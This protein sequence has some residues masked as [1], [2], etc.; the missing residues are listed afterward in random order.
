MTITI[1][2]LRQAGASDSL[3][4]RVA[5]LEHAERIATRRAQN[6]INKQNQRSRQ[7]FSAD[8][9]DSAD[10]GSPL[11]SSPS[12]FSPTPPH[13]TTPPS[14]P[15][16]KNVPSRKATEPVDEDFEQFW[17]G[18]PRREG[19]NPKHL[20]RRAFLA[21]R[22]AVDPSVIV[23]G[24]AAYAAS[25]EGVPDRKFIPMAATWLNQRRWEDLAPPADVPRPETP[26]E[27]ANR[28]YW[29]QRLA[30]KE[31][32]QIQRPVVRGS[33]VDREGGGEVSCHRGP[34]SGVQRVDGLVPLA[35]ISGPLVHAEC[36][37][38]QA[39][40]DLAESVATQSIQM[41]KYQ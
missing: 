8:S 2:M 6:R 17:K 21:A 16:P 23:R 9:A 7:Q 40:C 39:R 24:A 26:E 33:D 37:A 5:E 22:R 38:E 32:D 13:I 15:S 14:F 25:V 36:F 27:R 34:Q 41:G 10:K 31:R 19:P 20:A 29:Q 12:S 1:A 28:E 18:Y 3:I 30:E 35:R 4:A 11:P